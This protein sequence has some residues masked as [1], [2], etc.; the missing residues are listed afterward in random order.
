MTIEKRKVYLQGDPKVLEQLAKVELG[1]AGSIFEIHP[2]KF[3]NFNLES[4][5]DFEI[6]EGVAQKLNLPHPILVLL[7]TLILLSHPVDKTCNYIPLI[8]F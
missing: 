4:C 8:D 1:V 2:S 7:T 6:V 3:Q 5:I